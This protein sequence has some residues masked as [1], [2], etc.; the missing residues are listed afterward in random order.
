MND[1]PRPREVFERPRNFG[2]LAAA[3]EGSLVVVAVGAGW[4]VGQDPMQWMPESA[5][6]VAW[7]AGWGLVA[8][9]PPLGLLWVCLKCPARPFRRLVGVV[10][11]LLVPLFRDCRLLELA[12]IS[13]LAGLG[14]EMLFRGV[15]QQ[16]VAGWID[17]PSGTWVALVVA[18]ILFGLAHQVTFTYAVLAGL[19]GLYLGGIWLAG[20]K[21]L[22]LPI[23]THAMY[24]FLAL[25]YLVM[26]RKRT[27]D[28]R[29]PEV[30]NV[31]N[32]NSTE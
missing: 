30:P 4:L 25:V 21:N 6:D 22:L 31:R 20:E 16:A 7:G 18:A 23:V 9:V 12:V 3:F 24:D 5:A 14:E 26:I 13:A 2:L 17:G 29:P 15:I 27:S 1:D 28:G 32:D 8:T 10:D 19:I 11:D